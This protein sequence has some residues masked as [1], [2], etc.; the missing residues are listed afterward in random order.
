MKNKIAIAV[1]GGVGGSLS[2]L[3]SHLKETES[4]LSLAAL[5]GYEVLQ[6][7]GSALKAVEEAVKILEDDPHFN[8][9]RGSALNCK[10]EVQMDASIMN[11]KNLK[12]GA[13]SLIKNVRNPIS[14]AHAVMDKTKHVFLSGEG[15]LEV[16]NLEKIIFEVDSYFITEHQ[17]E[18]FHEENDRETL[19]EIFKKK[20]SGTVGAVAVDKKGNVAAATSTGGTNN[21]LAGRIG[22]SC[23]IGAGCYANNDTCAVSCTGEG[24]FLITG[25]IANTIALMHEFKMPLQEACDYVIHTRNKKVKNDMGVITV[26]RYGDIGY[27]FNTEI[28]RRA[29]ISTDKILEVKIFK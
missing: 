6:S 28:M 12:A 2:F 26:N 29:W 8:A 15:A 17:Y 27:A 20:M 11:G 13:V 23:I 16:A 5:T 22:D 25:V 3:S 24:E 14:L 10:G 19:Q 1:H 4:G 21:C 18:A 9:G 7:N